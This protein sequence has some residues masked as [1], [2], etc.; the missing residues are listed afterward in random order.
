MCDGKESPFTAVKGRKLHL[1]TATLL[2]KR[3]EGLDKTLWIPVYKLEL[4]SC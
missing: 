4:Y 3:N 1:S 2:F